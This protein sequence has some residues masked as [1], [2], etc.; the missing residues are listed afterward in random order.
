MGGLVR[1]TRGKK[2]GRARQI[3]NFL[4]FLFLGREDWL[5]LSFVTSFALFLF[6]FVWQFIGEGERGALV[7]S[8]VSTWTGI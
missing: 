2:A 3:Y 8:T 5:L 1:V 7:G 6:S 4:C